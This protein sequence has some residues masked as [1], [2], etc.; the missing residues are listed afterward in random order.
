MIPEQ[1]DCI[2]RLIPVTATPFLFVLFLFV[3]S[4]NAKSESPKCP[5]LTMVTE[6]CSFLIVIN[7][8][9]KENDDFTGKVTDKTSYKIAKEQFLYPMSNLPFFFPRLALYIYIYIF[10]YLPTIKKTFSISNSFSF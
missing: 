2:C 3:S 4:I 7:E 6:T 9:L 5:F 1:G 8:K 10:F